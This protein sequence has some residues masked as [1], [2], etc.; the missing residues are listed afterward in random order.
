M[1]HS[2]N[3]RGIGFMLLSGFAFV[4]NDSFMKLAIVDL[5]PYEV[6]LL[7]GLSGAFF[8]VILLALMGDLHQWRKV[9]DLSLIH[10]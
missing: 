1:A 5:P 10:I 2:S 8:A 7:R 6:L 9:Y 3:L 4:L